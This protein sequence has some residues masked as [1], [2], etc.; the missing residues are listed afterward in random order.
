[1][2]KSKGFTLIEVVV[3]IAII[4]IMFTGVFS[5]FDLGVKMFTKDQTQVANQETIRTVMTSIEKKIRKANHA[6]QPLYENIDGCLVIR[7]STRTDTYCLTGGNITL[8][9]S[10]VINRV[11]VF[12]VDVSNSN[13]TV[14][15]TISSVPDS[16]GQVNTLDATFSAR[17]G[18]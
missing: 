16:M 4:G 2:R 14:S 15:I 10:A 8:N 11:S 13:Y 3:V 6:S 18:R 17:Q 7:S 12:D 5:I 9:G 1:M